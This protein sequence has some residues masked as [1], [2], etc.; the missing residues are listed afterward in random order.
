MAR[1]RAKNYRMLRQIARLLV[2]EGPYFAASDE[3][4]NFEIKNLPTG[5]WS[6]TVWHEIAGRI[7]KVKQ[8]DKPTEWKFGRFEV[9]IKPGQ[10]NN[11]GKLEVAADLF[12]Y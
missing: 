1:T 9:T 11:L 8:N 6:F 2:R 12:E 10:T 5:T 4:G 3:N 7:S